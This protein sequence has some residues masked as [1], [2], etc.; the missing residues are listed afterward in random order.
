M[1]MPPI[2]SIELQYEITKNNGSI[3][4][5]EIIIDSVGDAIDHNS[6]PKAEFN[7]RTWYLDSGL[8]L[9]LTNYSQ[10]SNLYPEYLKE[11]PYEPTRA[12]IYLY[13]REELPNITFKMGNSTLPTEKVPGRLLFSMDG[14]NNGSIYLDK[15]SLTRIKFNADAKKL[16]TSVKLQV[17]NTE[18]DFD[19]SQGLNWSHSEIGADITDFSVNATTTKASMNLSI[20]SSETSSLDLPNASLTRAG[21]IT[22]SSQTLKGGKT[23]YGSLTLGKSTKDDHY[24]GTPILTLYS[25]KSS[26]S[27]YANYKYLSLSVAG[28]ASASGSSY[29]PT[30]TV[31]YNN[32]NTSSSSTYKTYT[33]KY[34]LD[35]NAFYPS[36]QN[37]LSYSG[38]STSSNSFLVSLGTSTYPWDRGYINTIHSTTLNA[39]TVDATSKVIIGNATLSY[40]TTNE[41]LDFTFS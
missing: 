34:V 39:T 37:S 27:S 6:I 1:A 30:F 11:D 29:K 2:E 28:T 35:Y 31:F 40:N 38:S 13:A 25:H 3:N 20:N 7:I 23:L 15:D 33:S 32:R 9:P 41:C 21:L 24:T 18:K 16:E 4:S 5:G 12:Y 17:G 10:W 26:S 36:S 14:D 19:G 8:T 22:T